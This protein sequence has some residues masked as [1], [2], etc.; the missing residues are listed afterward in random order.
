MIFLDDNERETVEIRGVKWEIGPIPIGKLEELE[1][2]ADDARRE[3]SRT[4]E[5][6]PERD[7]AR[8]RWWIAYRPVAREVVRWGVKGWNAPKLAYVAET[9]Q[10]AGATR[11]VLAKQIAERLSRVDGG[12]LL[13]EIAA[14]VLK[15]NRLA[16]DDILGFG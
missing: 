12:N 7:A 4:P 14:A 3:I 8:D 16:A 10:F 1:L 5:G 2:A 11:T 6:S 9:E 13:A 15:A